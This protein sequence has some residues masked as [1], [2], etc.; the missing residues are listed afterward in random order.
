[1]V[2]QRCG[3]DAYISVSQVRTGTYNG[4]LKGNHAL[5]LEYSW[6]HGQTGPKERGSDR[7]KRLVEV[8]K[9]L[10]K[11]DESTLVEN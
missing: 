3:Q 8:V 5:A 6:S 9:G 2:V 1:M 10:V 4:Y 7:S 11:G